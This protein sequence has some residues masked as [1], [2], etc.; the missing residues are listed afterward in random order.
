MRNGITRIAGGFDQ[1]LYLV[2]HGVHTLAQFAAHDHLCRPCQFVRPPCRPTGDQQAAQKRQDQADRR[3]DIDRVLDTPDNRCLL[4]RIEGDQQRAA[5]I[6]QAHD[7]ARDRAD[8]FRAVRFCLGDF[9]IDRL[10][11]QVRIVLRHAL[12]VAGDPAARCVFKI[13]EESRPV[14]GHPL[15]HRLAEAFHA[16]GEVGIAQLLKFE[17]H[18]PVGF[19]TDVIDRRIIEVDQQRR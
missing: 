6:P 10:N 12:E 18:P 15:E 2:E 19:G 16:P 3:G 17:I 9:E 5:I 13:V 1:L 8:N 14:T 4:C 11:I 7:A